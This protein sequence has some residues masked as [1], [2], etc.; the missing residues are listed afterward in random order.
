MMDRTENLPWT[1]RYLLAPPT[2][3][4]YKYILGNCFKMLRLLLKY[5]RVISQRQV[6]TYIY[7]EILEIR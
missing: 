3:I 2:C 1:S 5:S 4:L 6:K 7:V